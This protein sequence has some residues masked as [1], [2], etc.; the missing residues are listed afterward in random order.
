MA[1]DSLFTL[2]ICSTDETD[3]LEKLIRTINC[4]PLGSIEFSGVVDNP[5]IYFEKLLDITGYVSSRQEG[6]SLGSYAQ[7]GE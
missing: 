7:D 2:G 5:V 1:T 6:D 4:E 3:N